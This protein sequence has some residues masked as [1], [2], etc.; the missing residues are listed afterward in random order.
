MKHRND[1]KAERVTEGEQR[2]VAWRALP[3]EQQI[4]SL[5]T[6]QGESKRQLTKLRAAIA[7]KDLVHQRVTG[8]VMVAGPIVQI[9]PV[10]VTKRNKK[11]AI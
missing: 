3:P 4:A 10:P 11:K 7:A 1:R 2:N 9:D 8:L 5:L 6:R